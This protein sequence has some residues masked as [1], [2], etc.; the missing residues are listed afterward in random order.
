MHGSSVHL[1]L[2]QNINGD[3]FTGDG[4]A[5]KPYL[6]AVLFVTTE[7]GV[8]TGISW[9]KVKDTVKHPKVQ[10]PGLHNRHIQP[11]TS[12]VS[13]LRNPGPTSIFPTLFA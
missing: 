13:R 6:E 2:T 12:V 7:V 11:Q 8:A 4:F 9:G 3:G 5:P 10:R 1:Y